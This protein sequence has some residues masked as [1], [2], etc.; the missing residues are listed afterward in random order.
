MFGG[1]EVVAG[2]A[3]ASRDDPG[4]RAV[5]VRRWVECVCG[6]SRSR[7]CVEHGELP[8]IKRPMTKKL[9][10]MGPSIFFPIGRLP[11]RDTT[12]FEPS[13]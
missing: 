2:V 10:D 7:L 3:K 1:Y 13:G 11:W 12:S 4:P 6:E 9:S 8:N 5:D